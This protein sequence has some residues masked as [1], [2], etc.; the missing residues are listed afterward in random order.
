MGQKYLMDT[1]VL[2]DVQMNRLSNK[3]LDF[4]ANAINH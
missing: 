2:I 4:V 1:N 3:G